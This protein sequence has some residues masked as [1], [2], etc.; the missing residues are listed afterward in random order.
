MFRLLRTFTFL[1]LQV[2]MD[3]VA[4]KDLGLIDADA[5]RA[6]ERAAPERRVAIAMLKAELAS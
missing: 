5:K 3:Q 6:V 4:A 2:T 1:P